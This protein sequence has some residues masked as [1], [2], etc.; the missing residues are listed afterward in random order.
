MCSLTEIGMPCSGP[1]GSRSATARW[2]PGGLGAGTR[3][4]DVR[5]G[6]QDGIKLVDP[7]QEVVGDLDG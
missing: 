4:I 5:E 3:G 1:S 2:A 6:A 7:G